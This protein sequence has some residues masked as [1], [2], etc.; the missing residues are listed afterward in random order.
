MPRELFEA[1]CE[2]A[3]LHRDRDDLIEDAIA[4]LPREGRYRLARIIEMLD[5]AARGMP[6]SR[7]IR[8]LRNA[9]WRAVRTKSERLWTYEGDR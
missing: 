1:Q 5:D 7:I 3:E 8:G 2:R 6:Q 4:N 9:G